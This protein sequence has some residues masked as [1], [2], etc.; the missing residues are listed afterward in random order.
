MTQVEAEYI[1]NPELKGN[2]SL[3]SRARIVLVHSKLQSTIQGQATSNNP[4]NPLAINP[5]AQNLDIIFHLL[6]RTIG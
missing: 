6:V 5:L 2:P 3:R 4:K 1:V